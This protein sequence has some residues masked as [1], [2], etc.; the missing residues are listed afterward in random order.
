M[1]LATLTPRRPE[2]ME[3]RK[4]PPF[5]DM[6]AGLALVTVL[7]MLASIS[8]MMYGAPVTED[9]SG[10]ATENTSSPLNAKPLPWLNNK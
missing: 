1:A 2:F 10:F 9:F 7:L 5:T 6:L 4:L 3:G 8:N